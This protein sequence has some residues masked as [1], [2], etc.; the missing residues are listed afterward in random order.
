MGGGEKELFGL[1]L[2]NFE[3]FRPSEEG[4]RGDVLGSKS[5]TV[6]SSI[7]K[8]AHT[9]TRDAIS[10]SLSLS[11]ISANALFASSHYYY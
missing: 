3:K 2:K 5:I 8:R 4:M 10:L 7:S 6:L 11:L 9:R 1:V